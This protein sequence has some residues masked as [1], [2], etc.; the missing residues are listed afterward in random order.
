[1]GDIDL[2]VEI[3]TLSGVW[4]MGILEIK[5]FF[6]VRP[7]FFYIEGTPYRVM[8][9]DIHPIGCMGDGRVDTL[10]GDSGDGR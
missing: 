8:M 4:E 9:G 2:I 5:T 7:M 1:M 6:R 3:F 10:S